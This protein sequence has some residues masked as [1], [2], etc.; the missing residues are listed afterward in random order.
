M[1]AL[2]ITTSLRGR[3]DDRARDV[4]SCTEKWWAIADS[5][6][7]GYADQILA[8]ANGIIVGVF[9]VRGWRRDP[10]AN[11]KVVFGLAPAG[12]WQWLVGQPS[13]VTW[14]KA[15]ANPVR[16]L[17]TLMVGELRARR[18]HHSDA[19]HGWSLDVDADGQAATVRGP[20]RI[21]VTAIEHGTARLATSAKEA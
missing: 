19:G 18:P 9:D 1:L 15:Q 21:M 6:L 8:V 12:E 3:L 2:N 16:K 10:N 17:G 5:T 4:P 14:H 20:G 11:S 13:P 7:N